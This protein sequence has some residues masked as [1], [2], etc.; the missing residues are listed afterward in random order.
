MT[1][2]ESLSCTDPHGMLNFLSSGDKLS[3]RKA[4]LLAVAACRRL[5]L[6]GRESLVDTLAELLHPLTLRRV[7]LP[8]I[9][10]PRTVCD[11]YENR[12][13][14]VPGVSELE[15]SDRVVAIAALLDRGN[16]ALSPGDDQEDDIAATDRRA[17]RVDGAVRIRREV[18]HH[19]RTPV[20]VQD[21]V[22]CNSTVVF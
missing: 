4:Q 12:D 18:F 1:E 2:A 19:H 6:E 8:E 17:A 20:H 11:H 22:A 3:H 15:G 16:P 14:A 10:G 9:A 21:D 13:I 5:I 7:V